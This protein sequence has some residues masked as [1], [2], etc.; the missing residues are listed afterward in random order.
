MA[1]RHLR[2]GDLL[3]DDER[4]AEPN[5]YV[6]CRVCWAE[7]SSSRGDYFYLPDEQV[8]TCSECGGPMR[9]VQRVTRFHAWRALRRSAHA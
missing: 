5:V 4:T 3:T 6:Q 2:V 1:A 7:Y 9:L 8:M